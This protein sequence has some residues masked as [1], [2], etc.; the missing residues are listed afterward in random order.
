[1]SL[2]VYIDNDNLL[3]VDGVQLSPPAGLFINTANVTATIKDEIGAPLAG[4]PAPLVFPLVFPWVF[5]L[6][7]VY[8]AGSDGKYTG[9][10]EDTLALIANDEYTLCV[11][12]CAGTNLKAH[13]EASAKAIVRR[14][15]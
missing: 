2:L 1:M 12:I 6:G 14:G 8:V 5:P 3:T 7:L 15:S 9:I 13:Y 10:L 11:D 4:T